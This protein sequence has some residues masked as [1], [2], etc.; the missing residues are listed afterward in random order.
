MRQEGGDLS[1]KKLWNPGI[2][3]GPLWAL[4]G[5]LLWLR[6]GRPDQMV[7]SEGQGWLAGTGGCKG[8][9]GRDERGK[10]QGT[11][12]GLLH[13][14]LLWPASCHLPIWTTLQKLLLPPTDLPCPRG[15]FSRQKLLEGCWQQ[16]GHLLVRLLLWGSL[17]SSRSE[18]A[19]PLPA[20]QGGPGLFPSEHLSVK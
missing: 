4:S 16:A 8:R 3:P 18:C 17:H 6:R 13:S 10:G 19:R 2:G 9:A 1:L 5:H 12:M 11:W 14:S 7:T 20:T 15:K